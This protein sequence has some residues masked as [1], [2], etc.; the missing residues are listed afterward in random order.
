MSKQKI[1]DNFTQRVIAVRKVCLGVTKKISHFVKTPQAQN[2]I[3]LNF[4]KKI[5]KAVELFHSAE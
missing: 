5:R 3:L 1:T 2:R 4:E